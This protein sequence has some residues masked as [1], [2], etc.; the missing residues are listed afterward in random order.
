MKF[1]LNTF[2]IKGLLIS[3][4]IVLSFFLYNYYSNSYQRRYN[5]LES[6]IDNYHSTNYTELTILKNDHQ[7]IINLCELYISDFPTSKFTSTIRGFIDKKV[8]DYKIG[9]YLK[10]KF[11]YFLSNAQYDCLNESAN[12]VQCDDSLVNSIDILLKQ[13]DSL[14]NYLDSKDFDLYNLTARLLEKKANCNFPRKWNEKKLV[15]FSNMQSLA[16]LH[17]YNQL[18]PIRE[19]PSNPLISIP[20]SINK[21][22]SAVLSYGFKQIRRV[23]FNQVYRVEVNCYEEGILGIFKGLKKQYHMVK[24]SG[25]LSGEISNLGEFNIIP[26]VDLSAIQ[27]VEKIII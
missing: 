22:D 6:S 4:L 16:K 7:S 15:L 11:D 13:K 24:L 23:V 2:F 9:V 17:V 25:Q 26:A 8:F 14:V 21:Q 5:E 19:Q 20:I 10:Y 3:V 12:L 27:I 1:Q 18:G